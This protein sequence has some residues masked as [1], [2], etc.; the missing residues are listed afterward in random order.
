MHRVLETV[1]LRLRPWREEDLDPFA[2][3]CADEESRR[4]LGG[5]SGR[6]DAW[7][8]MAVIV[9]HWT[10]RGYGIWVIEDKATG[11]FAGY[12][13]LW[14]PEGWPGQEVTW[15]V[16]AAFRRRGYA[17]EAA[18][19]ARDFAYDE[20]KWPT[21]VSIIHPDN[22]ASQRVAARLGAAI[23]KR[24]ELRGSPVDIYRHPGPGKTH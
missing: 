22:T 4:Y 18:Q 12:S 3:F 20:L 10:L 1:R 19:R 8:S 13:G 14:S 24:T 5:V 15:S 6:P 9:G 23:E 21:A 7:R 2:A 11:A 16:C 17:V